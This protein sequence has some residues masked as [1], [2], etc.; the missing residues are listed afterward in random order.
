V[1]LAELAAEG[2][3]SATILFT[4]EGPRVAS[5][6]LALTAVARAIGA[7]TADPRDVLATLGDRSRAAAQALEALE[8]S[9]RACEL[10]VEGLDGERLRLVGRSSGALAWLR[11]ECG[12][13]RLDDGL[14]AAF[15]A[16][17]HP[18]WIAGPD[19]RVVRANRAWA[20][21]VGAIDASSGV[22]AGLGLPIGGEDLVRQSLARGAPC[23]AVRSLDLQGTSRRML[24]RAQP[25]GTRGAVVWTLDV[26]SAQEAARVRERLDR[27]F[28]LTLAHLSDAVAVFDADQRLVRFNAAF[29]RLWDL[30]PAWLGERPRHGAWLDRLRQLGRLPQTADYAAF[31]AQ[32]LA[33]HGASDAEES[34]WRLPQGE[35]LRVAAQPHPDGGLI[36]VFSDVTDELRRTSRF[37]QLVQ[38]QQASLDKLTDAVAVFGSDARLRLH[39]EA[40]QSLWS[41]PA[42]VLSPG[43]AYDDLVERCVARLADLQFWRSLK[44]RITDPDPALRA[45][46]AGEAQTWDG[47]WL[48]W[49]SRPLPDGA[50]LV[51]FAD[52]TGARGL[53]RALADREAALETAERLK[54]DFVAAVS[55][56]LRV[57]LTTVLGYAELLDGAAAPVDEPMRG[58]IG[59]VRAAAGVL[60]RAVD[61]ILIL[62]ELD[63]GERRLCDER[64]DLAALVDAAV[65]GRRDACE[66]AGVSLAVERAADIGTIDADPAALARVLDKLIDNAVAQTP[67]G[68]RITVGAARAHGEVLLRIADTGRGI[69]FDVQA[70]LFEREVGVE[71]G[72]AGLGLALVKALVELHGGWVSVESEPGRG[73]RF[74]CHLPEARAAE[75]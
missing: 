5:G 46:S 55:R 58:W 7:P 16:Y 68:G 9:G 15:D 19:G 65:A 53:Q 27:A 8:A 74:T 44:A 21:A 11:L 62:A 26:T 51:G 41:L 22:A 73:A 2:L 75:D 67:P 42:G 14:E 71:G 6:P 1:A 20:Q 3:G 28:D 47:R 23:E 40:F 38:V 10:D 17:P 56:E 48:A 30:T 13:A 33:R 52:V 49:Q 64:L 32:E 66:A 63:A 31:K 72:G 59:A 39:N 45:A 37:N 4:P 54:R 24:V 57:P 12:T 43:A 35:T 70:R 36:I 29:A 61:D 18:A 69:P 50:T 25:A 34:L 60:A